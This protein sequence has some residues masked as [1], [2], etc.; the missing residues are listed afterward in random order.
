LGPVEKPDGERCPAEALLGIS[1][2]TVQDS[3]AS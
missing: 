3:S 2:W 1:W